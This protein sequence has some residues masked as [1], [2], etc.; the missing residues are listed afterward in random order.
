[1]HLVGD[2][3]ASAL[4]WQGSA[5]Y[6]LRHCRR[7]IAQAHLCSE[8]LGIVFSLIAR[9]MTWDLLRDGD[10]RG[11][12]ITPCFCEMVAH[13]RELKRVGETVSACHGMYFGHQQ[14]VVDG[15]IT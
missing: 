9:R 13:L 15:E 10:V 5:L 8:V 3:I 14:S 1:M 11:Q 2:P 7:R 4:K 6:H 12:Q